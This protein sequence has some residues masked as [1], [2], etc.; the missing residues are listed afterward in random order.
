G[1]GPGYSVY[2]RKLDGS[3]AIRLG[4]GSAQA[5][6]PDGKLALAI[7]HPSSDSHLVIYPIGAGDPRFLATPGLTVQ[8]AS[9][10]PD[11]NHLILAANE[12]GHGVRIY[13]YDVAAQ[14]SR[15]LSPEGYRCLP[16]GLVSPDG[17]TV[18]VSGPD[19]K[20]YLYPV[21]GGEPAVLPIDRL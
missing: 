10:L 5:L 12:V 17:K 8:R 7:V 15:A 9:W 1:G 18:I 2:A 16:G 21:E 11:G 13:L 14:K 20:R 6:S 19:G 4:E 3:P